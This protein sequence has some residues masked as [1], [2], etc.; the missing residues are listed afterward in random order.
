M[1]TVRWIR[2]NRDPVFR[3]QPSSR[4]IFPGPKWAKKVKQSPPL[5]L[6]APHLLIYSSAF[7]LSHKPQLISDLRKFCPCHLQHKPNPMDQIYFR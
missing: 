4:L 6:Q 5:A 2:H 1:V 3:L 7:I